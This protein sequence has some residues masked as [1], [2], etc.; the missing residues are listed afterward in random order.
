MGNK[1]E[2]LNEFMV[3]CFYSILRDEEQALESLSNGKL[4]LKEI[5]VI[6]AVFKTQKTNSNTFSNIANMLR[7]KLGTLTESFSK[8]E[9]KG[10]LTK[11]QDKIDKRVY[12]IVPT[13]LGEMI[14]TEHTKWH[15]EL[16]AN[17]VK[18]IPEDD[19]PIFID[20]MKNLC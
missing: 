11:E 3:D 9:K 20:G 5:H 7:V 15:Q 2:V 8:L 6:E 14:N 19:I 12:Y 4:S 10:Y 16:I 17:V 1:H 18:T 13:R